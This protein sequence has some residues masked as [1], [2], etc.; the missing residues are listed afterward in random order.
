MRTILSASHVPTVVILLALSMAC[1]DDDAAADAAADAATDAPTDATVDAGPTNERWVTPPCD[2]TAG[3][4]APLSTRCNQ[5]VDDEGRVAVLRGVNARVEGIFDVTFDDGRERLQPLA[6]FEAEDAEQMRA[7]GLNVLRLP[8]NW[9][10]V[11]PEDTDPPTYVD[12]YLDEVARVV[13]LC[14]AAGVLVLIDFHQDAYSKEIGEDGAPLWA[15]QP[16]PEEL[17]EGPLTD[18]AD[19]RLSGQVL[20]AFRSFFGDDEPGPALR[21]RFASMAGHVAARFADDRNVVGYDLYNEPIG[22]DDEVLRLNVLVA[23]AIRE[24][25]PQLVFFEPPVVVRNLTDR[26]RTPTAPFPVAGAVYAPHV[27]TLSFIGSDEDRQ[28]MTRERLL[29]GNRSAAREAVAWGTPLFIG[30][31]GYDPEGI[32]AA[33]YYRFQLDL[34]DE[35]TASS[36]VWLWK[37]QSQDRWGFFDET[38]DGG[39][40]VRDAMVALFDRPYPERIAGWPEGWRWDAETGDFTLRYVGQEAVDAPTLLHLPTGDWTI[41]CDG[42]PVS[43]S[44]DALGR[45]EVPCVG[46]GAHEVVASR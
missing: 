2:A 9:S 10:A 45:V 39:W 43:M 28:N 19:R 27:Y 31:F 37:E 21:A 44:R 35:H 30:E 17:L 3:P 36:A 24:V 14:R 42:D 32:R 1:G 34:Q 7:L 15:I 22:S 29:V 5:L 26:S 8:I 46:V 11:E 23:E 38:D 41:T 18:L 6:D 40:A 33:D 25:S 13:D 4:F 12:A 20:R 16:P